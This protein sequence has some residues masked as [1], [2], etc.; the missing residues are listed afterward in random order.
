ME[1]TKQSDENAAKS[2]VRTEIVLA[3]T[4]RKHSST[5]A[6]SMRRSGFYRCETSSSLF[7]LWEIEG[8]IVCERSSS[9]FNQPQRS[10]RFNG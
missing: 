5:Q 6:P 3:L 7:L 4:P 1:K 2:P 10:E 9:V 8:V